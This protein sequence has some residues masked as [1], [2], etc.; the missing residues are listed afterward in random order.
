MS[1]DKNRSERRMNIPYTAESI[2]EFTATK[3]HKHCSKIIPGSVKCTQYLL[4]I[5]NRHV[6]ILK[7]TY[8]VEYE[9]L[10]RLVM[11]STVF[12]DIISTSFHVCILC[13]SFYHE[14]R[15]DI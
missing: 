12:W 14:D 15:C 1:E 9:V 7:L 2:M 6:Q 10:T 4:I 3:G 13:H 5:Q 11:T 8:I